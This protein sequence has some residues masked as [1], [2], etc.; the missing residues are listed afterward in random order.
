[1]T[2]SPPLPPDRLRAMARA[3]YEVRRKQGYGYFCWDDLQPEH[4]AEYLAA[5]KACLSGSTLR[6]GA[7][8]DQRHAGSR[9]G[10]DY[11]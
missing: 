9:G 11:R 1:M 4:Q 8:E 6:R 10:V 3:H 2:D 5:A 7:G